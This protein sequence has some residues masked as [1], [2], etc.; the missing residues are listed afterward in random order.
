MIGGIIIA[1]GFYT[2]MWGKAQEEKKMGEEEEN[3]DLGSS[4]HKAP[5][6]QNRSVDV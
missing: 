1:L 3:S 5:L 4:S 6:L 2:V